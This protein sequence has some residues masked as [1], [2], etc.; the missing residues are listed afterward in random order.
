M[1]PEWYIPLFQ[2]PRIKICFTI[3]ILLLI[4]SIICALKL[5]LQ[6]ALKTYRILND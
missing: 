5:E 2:H 1:L 3:L 4:F 6:E